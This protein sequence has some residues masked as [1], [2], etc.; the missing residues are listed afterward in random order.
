MRSSWVYHK[1][2]DWFHQNS[3]LPTMQYFPWSLST[4]KYDSY[5][6]FFSR[7]FLNF[8]WKLFISNFLAINIAFYMVSRYFCAKNLKEKNC[9]NIKECKEKYDKLLLKEIFLNRNPPFQCKPLC[10]NMECLI[11]IFAVKKISTLFQ[12]RKQKIFHRVQQLERTLVSMP[13]TENI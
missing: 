5:L 8:C 4:Y 10:Y 12:G 2:K 1:P 7:H 13:A 11:N 3:L 9:G 6:N